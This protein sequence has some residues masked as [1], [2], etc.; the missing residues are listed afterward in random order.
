MEDFESSN[1]GDLSGCTKEAD[2]WE[3]LTEAYTLCM[4]AYNSIDYY[5]FLRKKMKCRLRV[6]S[7]IL[8]IPSELSVC[9]VITEYLSV[10][11]QQRGSR[12]K[13]TQSRVTNFC[14]VE[15][16]GG[17][18]AKK[19]VEGTHIKSGKCSDCRKRMSAWNNIKTFLGL[20]KG[21]GDIAESATVE[22]PV[23]KETPSSSRYRLLCLY[24]DQSANRP[25]SRQAWNDVSNRN[26]LHVA[27]KLHLKG[28][29]AGSGIRRS[30]IKL[31]FRLWCKST[32]TALRRQLFTKTASFFGRHFRWGISNKAV[33]SL[34]FLTTATVLD[35]AP[36]KQGL[37]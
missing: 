20:K 1:Y 16:A 11:R 29:V 14:K 6:P 8:L 34:L 18:D 9:F 15:G 3:S 33:P 19:G 31:I 26:K 32:E 36:Y 25:L 13:F 30:P 22:L 5:T 10:L 17:Q 37:G 12:S 27:A 28:A 23:C 35:R 21:W 2:K 4:S 24:M 7:S